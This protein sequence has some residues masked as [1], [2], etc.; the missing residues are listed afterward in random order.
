M[1]RKIKKKQENKKH[2]LEEN[3]LRLLVDI[4]DE[5]DKEVDL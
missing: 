3:K 5:K 1:E 4:N 2:K